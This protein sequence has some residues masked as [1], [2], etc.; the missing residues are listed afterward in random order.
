M[1]V[2]EVAHLVMRGTRLRL[3]RRVLT[4]TRPGT[5]VR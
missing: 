3:A 2:F 1:K 4:D 5:R